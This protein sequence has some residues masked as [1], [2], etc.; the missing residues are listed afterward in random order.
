M[1]AT[2]PL[3]WLVAG[4][5]LL[6]SATVLVQARAAYVLLG[7]RIGTL[8]EF[9]ITSLNTR[10]VIAGVVS[11]G[12]G[13]GVLQIF[14][15]IHSGSFAVATVLSSLI[16]CSVVA[17]VMVLVYLLMLTLLKVEEAKSAIATA[18]GILRR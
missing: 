12:A 3:A 17:A 5:A 2:L 4:L 18:R 14:G 1:G 6:M 9:K 11:S 10:A 8:K 13:F 16:T 7:R 15:G